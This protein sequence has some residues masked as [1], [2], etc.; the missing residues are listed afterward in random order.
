[1]PNKLSWATDIEPKF[2]CLFPHLRSTSS[3]LRPRVFVKEL[4]PLGLQG[5]LKGSRWRHW[6]GS[7][8][9]LNKWTECK[10]KIQ[11]TR[12]AETVSTLNKDHLTST[13]QGWTG[14]RLDAVYRAYQKQSLRTMHFSILTGNTIILIFVLDQITSRT[15]K[16]DHY[17]KV[18]WASMV[19]RVSRWS[20]LQLYSPWKQNDSALSFVFF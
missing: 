15:N 8:C 9:L 5:L 3:N 14:G 17:G 20:L 12:E 2:C 11:R 4:R 16:G 6:S 1:M 13:L 7:K 10:S 19:E 18:W